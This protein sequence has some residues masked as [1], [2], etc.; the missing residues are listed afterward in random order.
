MS[1]KI[2]Y[3]ELRRLLIQ[4]IGGN[5]PGSIQPFTP[6]KLEEL[7]Q[8]ILFHL[9]ITDQ[10]QI[11]ELCNLMKEWWFVQIWGRFMEI[12]TPPEY[13]CED[14]LYSVENILFLMSWIRYFRDTTN[15]ETTKLTYTTCLDFLIAWNT[16]GHLTNEPG[17]CILLRDWSNAIAARVAM[18]AYDNTVGGYIECYLVSMREVIDKAN[19]RIKTLSKTPDET[20][21]DSPVETSDGGDAGRDAM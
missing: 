19:L 1:D 16:L 17:K 7:P 18:A 15:V 12:A 4:I 10:F 20:P 14:S 13:I 6:A 2:T 5:A 3:D 11:D 21:V 9:G 8:L